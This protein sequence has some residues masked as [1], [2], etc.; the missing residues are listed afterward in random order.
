[1]GSGSAVRA[2]GAASLSGVPRRVPGQRAGRGRGQRW[3]VG[4]WL[5]QRGNHFASCLLTVRSVRN[6]QRPM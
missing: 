2:A 5:H 4:D 3:A 6:V 1:M